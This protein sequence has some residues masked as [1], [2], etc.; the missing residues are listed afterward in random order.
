MV[1]LVA[2]TGVF[3]APRVE[4]G[5]IA[6]PMFCLNESATL[7]VFLTYPDAY[8][9]V[10]EIASRPKYENVFI[11]PISLDADYISD[12]HRLVSDLTPLKHTVKV[13][14]PTR[15]PMEVNNLNDNAVIRGD[16]EAPTFI[17]PNGFIAFDYLP[18]GGCKCKKCSCGCHLCGAD[19][20]RD[21][22]DIYLKWNDKAYL[23]TS[24]TV[25]KTRIKELVAAKAVDYI[26]VPYAYGPTEVFLSLINDT[27][28]T[29]VI[30]SLV[31]YGFR[32]Y[33]EFL[34]CY[35]NYPFNTPMPY[36]RPFLE[37]S[38]VHLSP[39]YEPIIGKT[40]FCPSVLFQDMDVP[41]MLPL[42]DGVE[43]E[44]PT[45][46][47]DLEGVFPE[48]MDEGYF[49]SSTCLSEEGTSSTKILKRTM[50]VGDELPFTVYFSGHATVEYHTVPETDSSLVEKI[51]NVPFKWSDVNAGYYD[52]NMKFI[53]V[54]NGVEK[55]HIDG[56]EL[57][58]SLFNTNVSE[59]NAEKNLIKRTRYELSASF[60]DF[61]EQA[62]SPFPIIQVGPEFECKD[63]SSAIA[64]AE[65][66]TFIS[67]ASGVYEEELSID[68][69][70]V[71]SGRDNDVV[72][73]GP[74]NLSLANPE[75]L[76]VYGT[77]TAGVCLEYLTL[78]GDA[79]IEV[80]PRDDALTSFGIEHCTFALECEDSKY[81]TIRTKSGGR[82]YAFICD[83]TFKAQSKGSYNLL[84]LW[85]EFT[86]D[87]RIGNNEFEEGCCTHNMINIYGA[88]DDATIRITDNHST[89]ILLNRIT[90][91]SN[92]TATIEITGNSYDK[93][94]T[95]E[96]DTFLLIQAVKGQS[97]YSG[98]TIVMG[99]NFYHEGEPSDKEIAWLYTVDKEGY[100]PW[101]D[102]N[103]P[104]VIIDGER[105]DWDMT[106]PFIG[107]LYR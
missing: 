42:E 97:D 60:I 53:K 13:I 36:R 16:K 7:F 75:D 93:P 21:M 30:P 39:D 2:L 98:T 17:F 79:K 86:M 90:L 29:D 46:P 80:T 44:P 50:G 59:F 62:E 47:M 26:Y 40:V 105:V 31:A 82:Y 57:I 15:Y 65:P 41:E 12:V 35:Q 11:V 5:Y 6:T 51:E 85:G 84:E 74:I 1:S 55:L 48:E 99:D 54:E 66:G 37:D 27:T 76:D 92:P 38:F 73:K 72:L 52:K 78:E 106:D 8:D 103:K 61:E 77:G 87:T 102:T 69:P 49:I 20:N 107:K 14:F 71:L 100:T 4:N 58:F 28:M 104:T 19:A 88:D 89:G 56:D 63:I 9:N 22:H 23:F 70:L 24:T 96:D 32:N 81:F 18:S 68:K 33:E 94:I 83:N 101:T 91:Y 64:I 67:L 45:I 34:R 95:N 25:N 10:F 43:K 3:Q